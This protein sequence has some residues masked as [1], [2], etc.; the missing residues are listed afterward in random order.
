LTVAFT[1]GSQKDQTGRSLGTFSLR[2]PNL[3]IDLATLQFSSLSRW[4]HSI[5]RRLGL[6]LDAGRNMLFVSMSLDTS[7]APTDATRAPF[8]T[9]ITLDTVQ[10]PMSW[11]KV[12]ASENTGALW[13]TLR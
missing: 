6:K 3:S 2:N 12:D 8:Q 7:Q 9:S 5:V 11:L 10:D 1:H 13:V 4:I